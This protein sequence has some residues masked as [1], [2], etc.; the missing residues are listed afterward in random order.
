MWVQAA[1]VQRNPTDTNGSFMKV[2]NTQAQG[3]SVYNLESKQ[4]GLL[5]PAGI[6]E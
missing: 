6:S 4:G 1:S 3:E 5:P 2:E